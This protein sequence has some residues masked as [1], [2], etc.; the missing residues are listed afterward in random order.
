MGESFQVGDRVHLRRVCGELA[1]GH[2]GTIVYCY[3]LLRAVYAV[4]F[5][6]YPLVMT[7]PAHWLAPLRPQ[8][9]ERPDPPLYQAPTS[10]E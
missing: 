2:A 10:A 4:Q 5:D 1:S 7:V 9:T 3:H 6:A 8:A